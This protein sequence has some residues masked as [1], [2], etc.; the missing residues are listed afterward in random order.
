MARWEIRT[1]AAADLA[2]VAELDLAAFNVAARRAGKPLYTTPRHTAGLRYFREAAPDLCLVAARG[3]EL[4]AYLIGHRWGATAW[5]GP[6]GVAPAHMGLGLGSAIVAEFCRRATA[7]GAT[8]VGLE[9]SL[10]YNVRLYEHLGFRSRA[11][12]V[13]A[14]KPVGAA[15]PTDTGLTIK[16]WSELGLPARQDAAERAAELAGLV[17]PGL[18]H[19][20]E[21]AAVPAAGMGQSLLAW[22]DRGDLAGY[23][24]VHLKG[25]REGTP[26]EAGPPVEP[27]VWILV[28]WPDAATA[29]LAR[30]EVAA[31]RAGAA[32]LRLS[33]YSGNPHAWVAAQAAGYKPEGAF[34]RLFYAGRYPGSG[35]RPGGEVPLD[36]SSWIG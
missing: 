13:R 35:D 18:D 7:S 24:V 9:T 5:T 16:R 6:L 21:I 12:T 15:G 27:L 32:E 1:M 20:V 11:L 4:L 8:T 25:Y 36:Y 23:A 34:V 19:G 30:C 26:P 17:S 2:G 29:L 22:D 31:A 10:A 33:C 28:G 3:G 14:V